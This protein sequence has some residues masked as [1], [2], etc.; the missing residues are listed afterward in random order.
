MNNR[1]FSLFPGLLALLLCP[2]AHAE[3]QPLED[4]DLAA[5]YGQA[6][7]QPTATQLPYDPSVRGLRLATL[8]VALVSRR[9]VISMTNTASLALMSPMLGVTTPMLGAIGQMLAVGTPDNIKRSSTGQLEYEMSM[10]A[11]PVSM[12]LPLFGLLG[13]LGPVLSISDM[14]MYETRVKV[15]VNTRP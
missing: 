10:P 2:L 6:F 13:G 9:Q 11:E 4:I 15:T 8:P 7:P 3:L 1:F 14:Q 5:V 12:Q